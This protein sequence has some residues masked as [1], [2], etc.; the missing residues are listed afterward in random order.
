MKTSSG[1]SNT[2]GSPRLPPSQARLL[3]ALGHS[4]H[5]LALSAVFS[6][7]P[8]SC[9]RTHVHIP[10]HHHPGTCP[11]SPSH[12]ALW[13]HTPTLKLTHLPVIFL[14]HTQAVLAPWLHHAPPS[15]GHAF[16]DGQACLIS[17]SLFRF[18]SLPHHT[19]SHAHMQTS[20]HV[21]S[22]PFS[23]LFAAPRL[24]TV[25]R[26]YVRHGLCT[27]VH[28]LPH[29]HAH[30]YFSSP[31]MHI[32]FFTWSPSSSSFSLFLACSLT[33]SLSPKHIYTFQLT[34]P[35]FCA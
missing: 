10:T 21:P 26:C 4:P 3:T 32:F 5:V 29:A 15:T 35:L 11:V 6:L 8:A 25:L 14:L 34:L 27:R 13:R 16:R 20:R 9:S 31:V 7:V 12:S 30:I 1:I 19:P 33:C 22:L 23:A 2:P 28:P 17:P 18:L 24:H